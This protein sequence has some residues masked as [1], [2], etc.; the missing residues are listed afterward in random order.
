MTAMTETNQENTKSQDSDANNSRTQ[1]IIQDLKD[2]GLVLSCVIATN[3]S[4][5]TKQILGYSP[6]GFVNFISSE[7]QVIRTYGTEFNKAGM[8]HIGEICDIFSEQ[9][10]RKNEEKDAKEPPT[11]PT[12]TLIPTFYFNSLPYG[13]RH[14]PPHPRS[15][16]R[17]MGK[18][19][20]DCDAH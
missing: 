2:R 16:R 10:I 8:H 11:P 20:D 3:P 4:T 19:S 14:P 5:G 12:P 6:Q 13:P 1:R 9:L 18:I 17:K 15:A 7:Y